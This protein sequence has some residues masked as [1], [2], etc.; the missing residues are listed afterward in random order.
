M[1]LSKLTQVCKKFNGKL[2]DNFCVIKQGS[3]E[4]TIS[5]WNPLTRDNPKL[6]YNEE[7]IE[8]ALRLAKSQ[9]SSNWHFFSKRIENKTPIYLAQAYSGSFLPKPKGEYFGWVFEI[10]KG[11]KIIKQK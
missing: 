8:T 7:D 4:V 10:R 3:Q 2:I 11:G 6:H 1:D 5:L 9:P